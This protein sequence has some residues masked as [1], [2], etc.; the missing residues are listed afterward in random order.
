MILDEDLVLL[1][2]LLVARVRVPEQPLVK[3]CTKL[4]TGSDLKYAKRK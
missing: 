3:F 4:E 1:Q 2:A